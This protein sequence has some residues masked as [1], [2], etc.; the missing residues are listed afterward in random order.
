MLSKIPSST[1]IENAGGTLW[2]FWIFKISL[3][4]TGKA[5]NNDLTADRI[6]NFCSRLVNGSIYYF[7]NK[8]SSIH[9]E[10][11]RTLL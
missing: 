10:N 3:I 7:Y 6:F 11:N 8:K 2:A 9:L 1:K 4:V 5:A